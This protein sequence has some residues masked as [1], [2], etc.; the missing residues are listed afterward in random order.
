MLILIP[1]NCEEIVGSLKLTLVRK[2]IRQ[3][4]THNPMMI[5]IIYGFIQSTNQKKSTQAATCILLVT[6]N[7]VNQEMNNQS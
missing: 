1:Y 6:H 5:I 7:A 3:N 4:T 2:T